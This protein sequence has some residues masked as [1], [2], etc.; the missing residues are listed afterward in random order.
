MA[1]PLQPFLKEAKEALIFQWNARVLKSR[2]SDI[3]PF[4]FK[5]HFP[6]IVICEPRLLNAI[7]LPSYEAFK[8]AT[9]NDHSNVIFYIGCELA[10][11]EQNV[12]PDDNNQYE[13]LT[14]KRNY[15]TFTI[16]DV[17]ISH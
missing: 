14:V 5:N 1:P 17:Y 12:P 3:R 8:S 6:S 13:C 10:Y 16:I 11:V 7:R 15:L 9:C 2:L 4:V